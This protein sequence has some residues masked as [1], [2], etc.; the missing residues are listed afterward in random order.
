VKARLRA[1]ARILYARL[2]ERRTRYLA[3]RLAIVLHELLRIPRAAFQSKE[4]LRARVDAL[5]ASLEPR[6]PWSSGH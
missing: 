4:H 6:P 1:Q 2:H 5:T 3:F